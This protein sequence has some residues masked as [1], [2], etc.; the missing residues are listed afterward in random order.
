MDD[1][2]GKVAR[3]AAKCILCGSCQ[4]VCPVYA[5]TLAETQ[6][7]RGRMALLQALIDGEL[8]LTDQL[9]R[10]LS[11][12]I[13]CKACTSA[14]PAGAAPDMA[15]LAA[16]ILLG[17][18]KGLPFYKQLITRQL[19]TNPTLLGASSR[20]VQTLGRRVYTPLAK[21]PFVRRVLPYV[22]DGIPRNLFSGSTPPFHDREPENRVP[23]A[24]RGRVAL[25]Y[26]CAI[27]HVYPEWGEKAVHL[28]NRA[29]FEVEMPHGLTC[30][31]APLLYAGDGD[32]AKEM[33]TK[34]LALLSRS[35]LDAIIT[36]CATCGSTLKELYPS[37]LE[38]DGARRL[39]EKVFDLQEFIMQGEL[40]RNLESIEGVRPPLRVTYHDPCHLNRGMGVQSAPRE[41]LRNLPG[42]DYVEMEDAGRCCGGGGLFSMSHYDLSLK[43]G[44]HKVGSIIAS[45]AEVVATGCPSCVMQLTDLLAREGA[46]IAVVH[47]C[48]LV[49]S[50]LLEWTHK[51]DAPVPS[52]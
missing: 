24:L 5:E 44:E 10:I 38:N 17:K 12:C 15:N 34:N 51:A 11:T 50:R 39:S 25:F 16:K 33:M 21:V 47:V 46:S 7:A 4:S 40:I 42:I 23:G 45:G 32:A 18:A 1:L 31:G 8:E 43:M 6:V 3:E 29:G 2:Q 49:A 19:L 9:T 37:F 13:G 26:G 14:C 27:D 20:V 30:C 41:I 22:R 28:L 52:V 48:D 35:D 36:L